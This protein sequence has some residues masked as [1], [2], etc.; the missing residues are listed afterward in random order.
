LP[1]HD[2]HPDAASLVATDPALAGIVRRFGPAPRWER[3]A[4]LPT[5][6]LLIL[7]QQVSLAS[8]RAAFDRLVAAAGGCDPDD[9]LAVDDDRM[10]AAGVSR[11]KRHYIRGLARAVGDGRLDLD[12]LS[13]LPDAA[14]RTSLTALPG[15]GPWTADTYLLL[16][17]GRPDVWPTGDV[18]L[19]DA[20]ADVLDLGARPDRRQLA[21][22]GE[23]WRPW[24]SEAARLLW[25]H[26]L[27]VRGRGGPPG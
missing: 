4:G 23:R 18:A 21:D 25:H 11:Q 26:Y 7:E 22:I 20:A 19:Q 2:L 15:L 9:L 16:A 3:P 13:A 8:A 17:L 1:R 14:A 12:G 27:S 5:L 6:V 24:R 10:L